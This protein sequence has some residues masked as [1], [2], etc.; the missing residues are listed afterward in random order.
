EQLDAVAVKARRDLVLSLGA[1]DGR[2]IWRANLPALLDRLEPAVA[3][4]GI[5]RVQIAPSCSLLHVP[6]DVSLESDLD[7]ELK[8]WL[9]FSVQKMA[10]LA[11]LGEAL[12]KGRASVGDALEASAKA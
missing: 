2:N 1:V 7:A 5:D 3:K 10:E 12:A 6:I 9:A 4:R 11:T 8:S